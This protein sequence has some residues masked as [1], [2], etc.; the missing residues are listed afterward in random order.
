MLPA[1]LLIL[2]PMALGT[3]ALAKELAKK[4]SGAPVDYSSTN[5]VMSQEELALDCRKLTGRMQVRILQI[6]GY[7][8]RRK[9]SDVSHAA[10]Q[11]AVPILGGSLRSA[12]PD[13]DYQRDRSML[14]AYNKQLAAKN[15]R[16]FDLEGEL[17]PK[18]VRDTPTPQPN[19]K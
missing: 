15:C 1:T 17:K 6:R 7:S 13:S 2:A 9:T 12:N 3:G 16:T 14:E 10:Q 11:A 5:Y 8:E 19:K 18:D 4:P